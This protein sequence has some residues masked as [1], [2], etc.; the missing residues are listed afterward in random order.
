[1]YFFLYLFL[2]LCFL[3]CTVRVYDVNTLLN[4]CHTEGF[5]D[6]DHFQVVITGFPDKRAKGL[7]AR[8]ESALFYAKSKMNELIIE[9]LINFW[10][11]KKQEEYK[12]DTGSISNLPEVKIELR[13]KMHKYL[14]YGY[15]AFE[16]YNEDDSAV[17]VYRVFKEAESKPRAN[18]KSRIGHSEK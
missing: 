3:S 16:F 5:L 7:V 11:E 10:L 12:V 14:E 15:E 6:F 13:S 1:M 18:G 9:R 4:D 8:R 2:F 17:I